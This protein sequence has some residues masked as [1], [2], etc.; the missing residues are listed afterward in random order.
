MMNP[1]VIL[2]I[3]LTAPI[4]CVV[5]APSGGRSS[6]TSTVPSN[7][8][9]GFVDVYIPGAGLQ[10]LPYV[11]QDGLPTVGDYMTLSWE[12]VNRTT[13]TEIALA[14]GAIGAPEAD[15]VGRALSSYRWPSG[16]IPYSFDRTT[17]PSGSALEQ[18]IV[19]GMAAWTA[20]TP[21]TFV[22][23][24]GSG[25]YLRFDGTRPA[26]TGGH[27]SSVGRIAGSGQHQINF[28]SDVSIPC[29]PGIPIHEIGHLIGLY[30]EQQ[31]ADRDSYVKVYDGKSPVGCTPGVNCLPDNFTPCFGSINSDYL[32]FADVSSGNYG[33]DGEDLLSFDWNSIM[34][35][36]GD[37]SGCCGVSCM[38]DL[39]G[40]AFSNNSTVVSGLDAAGVSQMYYWIAW[41]SWIEPV[42][43]SALL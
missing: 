20:R 33:N 41:G 24:G 5:N 13:P 39:S 14:T 4:A 6:P 21:I 25:D 35:Y 18:A 16:Q 31:R 11:V 12:Q 27:S 19:A 37:T 29:C 17:I 10:H 26:G 40:V 15:S 36:P 43:T 34:L 1:G 9:S 38:T 28:A 32:R 42:T 7:G 3:C 8:S 23:Y 30:H 2:T 22:P